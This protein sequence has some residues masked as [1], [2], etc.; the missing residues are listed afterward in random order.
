MVVSPIKQLP[1]VAPTTPTWSISP[2]DNLEILWP[3]ISTT[4]L[5]TDVSDSIGFGSI[6]EVSLESLRESGGFGI[7]WERQQIITLKEL[8]SV[9]QGLQKNLPFIQGQCNLLFQDNTNVVESLTKFSSRRKPLM[10]EFYH[11]DMVAV[12]TNI[13]RGDLHPIRTQH[14]RPCVSSSQC[15]PLDPQTVHAKFL[16]ATST[17]T[18]G[19]TSRHRP[20][21]MLS[22]S[23][24]NTLLYSTPRPPFIRLQWSAPRLLLF[25]IKSIGRLRTSSTSTRPGISKKKSSMVLGENV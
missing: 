7:P 8:K 22:I 20:I 1:K 17:P 14:H 18:S 15:R 25:I 11:I 23:S 2:P 5:T 24:R 3:Q 4:P 13:A 9:Q 6:L 12:S 21:C 16:V 10:D 19:T